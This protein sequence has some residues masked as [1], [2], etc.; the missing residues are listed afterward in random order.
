MDVHFQERLLSL[1]TMT[2]RKRCRT[3]LLVLDGSSYH[4]HPTTGRRTHPKGS[5]GSP[6]FDGR[7]LRSLVRG[8]LRGT[9][10][11]NRDP[12][13]LFGEYTPTRPM[14]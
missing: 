4:T 5:K 9:P 12:F 1:G 13:D 14:K 7:E 2:R 10:R 8:T 3:D 11:G 6:D